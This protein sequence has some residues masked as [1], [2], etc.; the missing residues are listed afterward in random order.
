MEN[1]EDH[2][3]AEDHYMRG[4]KAHVGDD[5]EG[6]LKEFNT[7]KDYNPYYK[8]IDRMIRDLEEI[9]KLKKDNKLQ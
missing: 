7:T 1:C 3:T 8:S 2:S 9:Q 6:A 4:I 5:M